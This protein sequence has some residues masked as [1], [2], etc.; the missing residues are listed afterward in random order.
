M[1][2]NIKKC[3]NKVEESIIELKEF[4]NPFSTQFSK[5]AKLRNLTERMQELKIPGIS[6]AVIVNNK[7]DWLK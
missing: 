7:I 4:S 2:K 5:T 6:I 1:N 3:I